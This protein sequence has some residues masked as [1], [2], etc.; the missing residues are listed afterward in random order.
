MRGLVVVAHPDDE[1]L[2]FGGLLLRSREQDWTIACA[3]HGPETE[4]GRD[5][6][7]VCRR[8][9]ARPRQLGLRDEVACL[10]DEAALDAWLRGLA[11]ED[12]WQV[13]LTHNRRGEYGHP[14]HRQVG[15]LA[16]QHWPRAIHCGFG[17]EAINARVP[18][19]AETVKRKHALIDVYLGQDKRHR[20]R[21]Y[22][23]YDCTFEPLWMP[24]GT[25]LP[26][27]E[28]I[29]ST[30]WSVLGGTGDYAKPSP[31]RPLR[32]ALLTDS[33]GWAHDTVA[34]GLAMSLPSD[35][36]VTIHPLFDAEFRTR[37]L[38]GFDHE[39][40]DLVHLLSWRNFADVADLGLPRE[41]LV[42]TVHGH[43]GL[44]DAD[45]LRKVAEGCVRMSVVSQRLAEALAPFLGPLP[46]TPCGV[47]TQA[48]APGGATDARGGRPFSFC[49]VGRLYDDGGDD[50]IKGW[51]KV[52][53]PLREAVPEL[54]AQYLVVDRAAVRPHREMPGF[55]QQAD[56]YVCAS[57]SEGNP[58]PLLE[59]AA[60][61][62]PLLSTDVGVAPELVDA[63]AGRLLPRR[64][65]D[66]ALALRELAAERAVG[67]E[68]GRR[69]RAHM[70]RRRDWAC[71]APRWARFY[72]E[73]SQGRP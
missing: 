72:A 69:A 3:T 64:A 68:M 28:P 47:D 40:Y 53:W 33:A 73:A 67:A 60:C 4:R 25:L 8:L 9:G 43:R 1:L 63:G 34:R 16:S 66:F 23:A 62:L 65:T 38:V 7:E 48:F 46:L 12:A 54:G 6:L 11:E 2:W 15:R 20:L 59:A 49:A 13:V 17:A 42:T 56:C 61:G 32:L 39:P 51:R 14:H 57:A 18:L 29:A 37:L 22:P 31:E 30:S 24:T 5:F 41:K 26:A 55:Y 58:L 21:R 45:R 10:L 70:L 27:A 36:E 44:D 50:D 19:D 35:I 71:V 52:L